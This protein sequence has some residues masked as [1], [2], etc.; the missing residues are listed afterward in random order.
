M[1]TVHLTQGHHR[2]YCSEDQKSLDERI[3]LTDDVIDLP[4]SRIPDRLEPIRGSRAAM[5]RAA[6]RGLQKLKHFDAAISIIY[7]ADEK[8]PYLSIPKRTWGEISLGKPHHLVV[9]FSHDT[10]FD[11]VPFVQIYQWL[12]DLVPTTADL[13]EDFFA[14]EREWSDP[15]KWYQFYRKRISRE[16]DRLQGLASQAR[17]SATSYDSAA[18]SITIA[19]R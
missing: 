1:G 7:I 12:E 16:V 6:L 14:F 17:Q 9:S 2:L 3:L 13:D 18:R 10:R 19:L 4:I 15:E 11:N 5:I 8:E